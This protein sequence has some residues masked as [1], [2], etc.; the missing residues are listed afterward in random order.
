MPR[1]QGGGRP[2]NVTRYR[3]IKLPEGHPLCQSDGCTY[4]HRLIFYNKVDGSDQVCHW[5]Q[6][7][8]SWRD[9]PRLV[10]D[11]LD[12]DRWNNV[13]DNLVAACARCNSLRVIRSDWLT[14]C[15]L[16][17]PF[18]EENTYLRPDGRG[19]QCRICNA[20]REKRRKR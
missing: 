16:G 1:T 5:C 9:K 19:R 8:L 3:R 4:E 17:H 2:A 12:G 20:L 13:P 7:P 18:T 14:H 6:K 10:V 11:H 15:H